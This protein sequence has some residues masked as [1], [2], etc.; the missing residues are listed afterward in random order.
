MCTLVPK[1]QPCLFYKYIV[2]QNGIIC[3][4]VPLLLMDI[5]VVSHLLP[6]MNNSVPNHTPVNLWCKFL[7]VKFLSQRVCTLVI[8][9][10]FINPIIVL[11]SSS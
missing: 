1:E 4:A 8:S 7:K 10:V 5:L 2:S 6:A 3:L 11:L 9:S